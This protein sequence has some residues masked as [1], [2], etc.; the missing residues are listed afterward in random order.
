MGIKKDRSKC[1]N[2][3]KSKYCRYHQDQEIKTNE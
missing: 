2:V 3:Q 1:G